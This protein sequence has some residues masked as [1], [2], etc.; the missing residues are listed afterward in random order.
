M[1]ADDLAST[2]E[3]VGLVLAGGGTRGAYEL[4]VLS[5][6][7]PFLEARGE[8]PSIVV[9][10]SVG[11]INAAGLAATSHLPARDALSLELRRWREVDLGAVIQPI[12]PSLPLKLLRHSFAALS[13]PGAP[14]S[15]LLDPAPLTRNLA[16]WIEWD[17]LHHNLAASSP[18]RSLA[19][20]ATAARTGRSVAFVEGHT[21][22][23]HQSRS[24]L[25]D[26]VPATL[27]ATHVLASAA[28][29][30]LFPAVRVERPAPARGWYIDGAT[31]LNTPLKPA[32]DLGA[33]RLVVIGTGSAAP[34]PFR[35]GYLDDAPAPDLGT[36]VS[37]LLQGALTDPLIEDLRTLA[38]INSAL[39]GSTDPD[40]PPLSRAVAAYDRA[41]LSAAAPHDPPDS[42]AAASHHRSCGER[43]HKRI[44]YIFIAPPTPATIANLATGAFRSRYRGLRGLRSPDL[45]LLARL[46]GGHNHSHGDLLSYLLFDPPFIA[47]L[48]DQGERDAA[49]WLDAAGS[50]PS[51]PW[52]LDPLDG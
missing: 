28:I 45:A 8:R 34:Q 12:L 48:I 31:R 16:R 10:T 20:I 25:I 7:L 49:A 38:Q 1:T 13:P 18:T 46:L 29:P 39:E 51:E 33:D 19:V 37:H 52:R 30:L 14:L 9:G 6:L 15:S 35:P 3:R 50:N 2:G 4:G 21:T 36:S 32:L 40:G 44:P 26:Y 27:D 23:V 17:Q 5:V 47:A 43:S 11:A 24:A 41:S 22:A 42:P